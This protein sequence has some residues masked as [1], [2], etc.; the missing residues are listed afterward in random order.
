MER[1]E[2]LLQLGLSLARAGEGARAEQY[3]VAALQEG[4]GWERVVVPLVKLCV[5]SA[6]YQSA[7]RYVQDGLDRDPE[8]AALHYLAASLGLGL[9]KDDLVRHHVEQLARMPGLPK[10]AL[11]FLGDYYRAEDAPRARHFYCR[12]LEQS[13]HGGGAARARSQLRA[14]AQDVALH[15]SQTEASRPACSDL[16]VAPVVRSGPLDPEHG[17][18]ADAAA[19][20]SRL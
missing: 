19:A 4:A 2:T 7:L 5:A 12:Y 6:R 3:L 8:S 11:L 20:G 18:Q 16:Y 13:P 17:P 1:A 14:D 10:E 9:G 15:A